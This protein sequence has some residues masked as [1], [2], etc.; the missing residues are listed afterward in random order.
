MG[1]LRVGTVAVLVLGAGFVAAP[2]A[3]AAPSTSQQADTDVEVSALGVPDLAVV[4]ELEATADDSTETQASDGLQL[5]P[6][7]DF[8]RAPAHLNS[9][10]AGVQA[11]GVVGELEATTDDSTETQPRDGL[12]LAPAPDFSR[13]PVRLSSAGRKPPSRLRTAT[14]ATLGAATVSGTL[15]ATFG[16]LTHRERRSFASRCLGG[17]DCAGSV[18]P[19]T[20]AERFR[21][22]RTATNVFIASTGLLFAATVSLAIV[23]RVQ[24]R[25]HRRI[26]RGRLMF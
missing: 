24:R 13:A 6:A 2:V 7:P 23:H 17:D 8:S 9:A 19:T 25:K 16:A 1:R 11:L 12:Q 20:T 4:V 22:Y 15:A 5:A 26:E 21:S 3:R 14:W 18:Y 10:E